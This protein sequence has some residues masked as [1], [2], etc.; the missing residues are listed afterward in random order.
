[1]ADEQTAGRGRLGRSWWAGPEAGLLF[2][3]LLR[4]TAFPVS[5]AGQL[6]MCLGL[7]AAEGIEATTGVGV[8]LKWPNDV[9]YEGRKL[10]GMLAE[11][12]LAGEQVAYAVLGLGLNAN[13]DFA[14]APADLTDTAVSLALILG[15]EVDRAALLAALLARFEQHYDRLLAGEPPH[16][17]WAARLDTLGRRVRVA[18]PAASLTG[19]ATG[20]TPEGA[21]L[22]RT[23]DGTEHVVWSGDVTAVRPT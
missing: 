21:L 18:L 11:L 23:D 2:S 1:V 12:E 10:G 7:A 4:P 19:V 17:A 5:R 8:A 20:V 15:H 13:M 9:V 22:L 16:A 6:T 14:A 3:L